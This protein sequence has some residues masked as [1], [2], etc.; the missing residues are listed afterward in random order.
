MADEEFEELPTEKQRPE[1]RVVQS[2]RGP[3]GEQVYR[4]VG[5]AWK[6]ISKNGKIF[7]VL[8]IGSMRLLMFHA[9]EGGLNNEGGLGGE[10]TY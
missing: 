7:Y 1:F 9:N 5:A 6:N 10:E 3:N 8:K 2:D 4:N